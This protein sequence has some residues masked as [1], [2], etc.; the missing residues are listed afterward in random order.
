MPL[1][2]VIAHNLDRLFPGMEIVESHPFRVTR[3]ADVQRN[4][5]TAEDLLEAIQEELRERRFATIVRLEVAKGMPAGCVELLAAELE[6]SEQEIF[7][8]DGLLSLKDLMSLAGLLP[9]PSLR[10]RP[11]TPVVP[12]RFLHLEPD[13]DCRLLRRHR[14]RATSW[15]TTPTTPSPAASSASSRRR[16]PIRPCWPS[17]RRST[18]PRPARRTCRR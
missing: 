3:N 13:E 4:E 7:E 14:R 5:E 1:E 16:R 12:P 10:Y 9:L 15:S 6:V 17:S 11:W 18:A 2:E 8:V